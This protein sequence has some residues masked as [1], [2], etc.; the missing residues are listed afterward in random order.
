M[1]ASPI[2]WHGNS[3][4]EV[5][6]EAKKSAEVSHNHHE[7][8]KGAQAAAFAVY[9]ARIGKSKDEI[10]QCVVDRFEYDIDKNAVCG[11]IK[12]VPILYGYIH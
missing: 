11:K 7:G 8:I 4:D 1:R 3:I 5:L 2:G 12:N 6:S 9:L 10:K